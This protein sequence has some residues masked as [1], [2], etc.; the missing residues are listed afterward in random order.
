MQ[1]AVTATQFADCTWTELQLPTGAMQVTNRSLL[2]VCSRSAGLQL[3]VNRG[4][5]CPRPALGCKQA[6]N[7]WACAR[8]GVLQHRHSNLNEQR[9]ACLQLL[10]CGIRH[11]QRQAGRRHMPIMTG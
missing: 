9:W 7:R 11:T 4:I 2:H 6:I 5:A 10:I 1:P 3:A 8:A